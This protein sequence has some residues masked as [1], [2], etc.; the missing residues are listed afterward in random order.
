MTFGSRGAAGSEQRSRG[1]RPLSKQPCCFGLR[2]C[3]NYRGDHR[4][5]ARRSR[6]QA[7]TDAGKIFGDGIGKLNLDLDKTIKG[8]SFYTEF[9]NSPDVLACLASLSVSA[10][11]ILGSSHCWARTAI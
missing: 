8:L 11:A 7:P 10:Y 3:F 4:H 9:G 1:A 2:Q 6:S 5:R